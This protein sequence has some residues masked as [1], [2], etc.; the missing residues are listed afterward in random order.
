MIFLACMLILGTHATIVDN[1]DPAI[2]YQ[3]IYIL[4]TKKLQKISDLYTLECK[5]CKLSV[6]EYS[7]HCSICNRCVYEFDHHCYWLNNCIGSKNYHTFI[8]SCTSLIVY[9]M[10]QIVIYIQF[11]TKTFYVWILLFLNA[12]STILPSILMGAHI[13]LKVKGLSTYSWVKYT[14]D[15]KE[16]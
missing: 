8:L 9:F 14:S 7:R 15:K 12:I 11:S 10:V 2:Y 4:D 6:H 5:Y 16:K 13:F 1:T 3:R